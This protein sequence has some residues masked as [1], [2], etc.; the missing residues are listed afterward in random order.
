MADGLGTLA[1]VALDAADYQLAREWNCENI[2]LDEHTELETFSYSGDDPVTLEVWT[3]VATGVHP[4]EHGMESSGEQQEWNN[5][6]LQLASSV[7]PYLLPKELRVKLGTML[8]GDDDDSVMTFDSTEH[9]HVFLM[10][11]HT[12]GRESLRGNISQKLG[13][14]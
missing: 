12:D 6:L 3:S 13:T 9:D 10:V 14:G 4:R 7:T 11:V 2:L 8:R 1:V 5:P